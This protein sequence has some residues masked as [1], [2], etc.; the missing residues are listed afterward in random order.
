[1]SDDYRR[2]SGLAGVSQMKPRL[3]RDLGL[4]GPYEAMTDHAAANST[5]CDNPL[6]GRIGGAGERIFGHCGKLR[7]DGAV[8]SIHLT[9]IPLLSR[10]ETEIFEFKRAQHSAQ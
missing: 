10:G 1:M 8:R 7:K 2:G 4:L 3:Q 5:R 6:S 9:V